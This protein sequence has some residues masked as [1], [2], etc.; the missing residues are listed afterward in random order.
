MN[1]DTDRTISVVIPVYNEAESLKELLKELDSAL[2]GTKWNAIIVDDGSN[3][4]TWKTTVELSTKYPVT[5]LRLGTNTGKAAA[6][7]AGFEEASG[8]YIA[9]MDGDLQD[10]PEEIPAM[11]ELMDREGYDLVSGWKKVRHDPL[12]KTLQGFSTA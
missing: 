11:I 4:S 6:L 5:G 12:G 8:D 2:A 10:D 7:S 1:T 3:D 9:T